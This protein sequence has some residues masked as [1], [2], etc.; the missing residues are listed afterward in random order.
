MR[1]RAWGIPASL[2][3]LGSLVHGWGTT[4]PWTPLAPITNRASEAKAN[5]H[6]WMEVSEGPAPR[7]TEQ[8]PD[9]DRETDSS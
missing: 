7:I 4:F 1:A 5:N 2:Y 6:P 8:E 3:F 9:S